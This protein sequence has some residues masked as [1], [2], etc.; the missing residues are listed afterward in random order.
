[1]RGVYNICGVA[2]SVN[3]LTWEVNLRMSV[4]IDW[5]DTLNV[6]VQL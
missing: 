2:I 3:V 1:M 6:F 5:P 4:N